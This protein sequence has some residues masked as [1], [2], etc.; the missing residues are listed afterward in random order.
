MPVLNCDML[1]QGTKTLDIGIILYEENVVAQYSKPK[2]IV[3]PLREDLVDDVYKMPS[4]KAPTTSKPIHYSGF[5]IGP[6]ARVKNL[7]AHMTI[8]L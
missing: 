4:S 6:L 1:I 5:P 2:I 3:P 8:L 7:E